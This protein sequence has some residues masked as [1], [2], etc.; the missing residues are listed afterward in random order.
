MTRVSRYSSSCHL[1]HKQLRK[2]KQKS[3]TE[4]EKNHKLL[5]PMLQSVI[6]TKTIYR[7]RGVQ[8]SIFESNSQPFAP[9]ALRK[10]RIPRSLTGRVD[11][12]IYYPN[13]DFIS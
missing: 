13:D 3:K 4:E 7:V 1:S 2:K 6:S 5:T 12:L 8:I 9:K 10:Q 11:H